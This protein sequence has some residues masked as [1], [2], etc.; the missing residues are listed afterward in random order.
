MPLPHATCRSGFS[1]GISVMAALEVL[2]LSEAV[3]VRYSQ[4]DALIAQLEEYMTFNLGVVG[5]NP[6]RRT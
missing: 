1:L 4:Q 2:V 6:T 5:S 3:R